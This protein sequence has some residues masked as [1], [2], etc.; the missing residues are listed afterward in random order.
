[1][2]TLFQASPARGSSSRAALEKRREAGLRVSS[3]IPPEREAQG[4]KAVRGRQ[5]ASRPGGT[6]VPTRSSPAPPECSEAALPPALPLRCRDEPGQPACSRHPGTRGGS[7]PR[8]GSISAFRLDFPGLPWMLRL[9][10]NQQA[11][12]HVRLHAPLPF[13][14]LR[15]APRIRYRRGRPPVRLVP[16]HPRPWR[17]AV[18]RPARPLRHDAVRGR[19]GFP[20]LQDG[21]DGCAPNG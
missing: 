10:P 14:H 12:V 17:R 20:G 4:R 19:S 21:R 1:M 2:R 8:T 13:P 6:P 18:H 9:K 11:F 15:R 7:A 5:G 3:L 16:P